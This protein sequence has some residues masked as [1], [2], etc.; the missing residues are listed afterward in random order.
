MCAKA[1][2]NAQVKVNTNI[3]SDTIDGEKELNCKCGCGH[4]LSW[5]GDDILMALPCEHLFHERCIK[6]NQL[7]PLCNTSVIKLVGMFDDDIHPQRF[8]DIMSMSYY[9][10]MS[11]T[12][13]FRLMDSFFDWISVLVL[14]PF[15]Q[16]DA[17]QL[18]EKILTLNNITMKVSG[19]DKLNL[20]SKKV[21][22]CNHVS[23]LELI[24]VH[25]LLKTGFLASSVMGKSNLAERI[26]KI[27]PLL[28]VTR[29]KNKK[30]ND[31]SVIIDKIKKFVDEHGSICI[32]PEGMMKH[33]DTLTKF[34]TGAFYVGYPVY[35]LTIRHTNVV[36]DGS[37]KRKFIY[38]RTIYKPLA[39]G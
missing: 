32:F 9:D 30:N 4:R 20:E 6:I 29:T 31:A 18:C 15:V 27:V 13:P 2:V 39:V 25:Y 12:H 37:I 36:A 3:D 35:S 24:I 16:K 8:S 5:K 19:I 7:C 22:I 11:D 1:N 34:R 26:K 38:K 28:E 17:T 14:L 23:H 33:P 21:Y 10:D